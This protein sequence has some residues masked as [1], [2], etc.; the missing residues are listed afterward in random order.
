VQLNGRSISGYCRASRTADE[1][2]SYKT[3]PPV[4]GGGPILST[5]PGDIDAMDN[6]SGGK[7]RLSVFSLSF[8]VRG[9]QSGSFAAKARPVSKKLYRQQ[10]AR[11]KIL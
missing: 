8:I 9:I 3:S 1:S 2:Q 11:F 5:S 6:H 4:S 10:R 7:W